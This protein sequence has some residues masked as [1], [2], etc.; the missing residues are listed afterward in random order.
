MRFFTTDYTDGA[1]EAQ[2]WSLEFSGE[3]LVQQRLLQRL[4]RGALLFVEAGEALGFFRQG[5]TLFDNSELLLRV[6]VANVKRLRLGKV[7]RLMNASAGIPQEP[8]A[9]FG[10]KDVFQKVRDQTAR[11][12]PVHKVLARGHRTAHHGHIADRSSS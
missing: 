6:W 4:Q 5:V 7:N 1:D 11:T 3:G 9:T 10:Q 2:V 12:D 8:V